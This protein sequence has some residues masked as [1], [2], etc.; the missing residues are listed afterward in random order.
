MSADM[1]RTL[2]FFEAVSAKN[3]DAAEGAMRDHWQAGGSRSGGAFTGKAPRPLKS[4]ARRSASE[5]VPRHDEY[6]MPSAST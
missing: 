6:G 2:V 1:R 4:G 5:P 3:A